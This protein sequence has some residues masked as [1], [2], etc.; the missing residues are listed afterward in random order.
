MA[1]TSEH[2]GSQ[3]ETMDLRQGLAVHLPSQQNF[4][5]LD[6]S[7]WYTD[8]VV[9]DFALLEVGISSKEL[10]V[11]AFATILEASTMLDDFLQANT[12]PAGRANGTFTPGCVDQLITV[13]GILVD[14][15]NTASARALQTDNVALA[16]EEVF[17][18]KVCEGESFW[19]V[20]QALNVEG[21]VLRL[22]FRNTAVVTDEVVLVV[23]HFGLDQ[24]FLSFR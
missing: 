18:L 21:V 6:L 4:I 23:G 16:R 7:P 9:V 24:A 1:L 12:R 15:L 20:D 14:L 3:R 13:T 11:H 2:D 10:E 19:V 8:N 22:N 17:V 5:D